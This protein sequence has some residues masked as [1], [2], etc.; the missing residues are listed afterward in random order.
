[1]YM[2]FRNSTISMRPW[3]ICIDFQGSS[4][5]GP[6]VNPSTIG[7]FILFPPELFPRRPKTMGMMAKIL[8]ARFPASQLPSF[9][10]RIQSYSLRARSSFS[11]CHWFRNRV[12]PTRSHSFC[13]FPHWLCESL[14]AAIS[15]SAKNRDFALKY[16][17]YTNSIRLLKKLIFRFEINNCS[18]LLIIT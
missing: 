18:Q 1:M 11:I 13:M 14:L 12:A 8:S 4:F 9:D 10:D 2:R 6:S 17:A 7:L 5:V 16:F 15:I 3:S